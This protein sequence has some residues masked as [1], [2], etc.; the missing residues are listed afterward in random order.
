MYVSVSAGDCLR[1]CP[2]DCLSDC[3]SVYA[4]VYASECASVS[5]V[6]NASDSVRVS[7]GDNVSICGVIFAFFPRD[8]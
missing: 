8:A 6:V 7:V 1:D 2:S 4:S 3:L 5:S